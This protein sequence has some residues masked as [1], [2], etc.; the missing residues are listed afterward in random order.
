MKTFSDTCALAALLAA[1]TLLAPGA[2]VWAA[3]PPPPGAPI[4]SGAPA[5]TI[6]TGTYFSFTPSALDPDGNALS[7]T[8]ANKPS[9]ATFSSVTGMLSGTPTAGS[10]S[11]IQISVSDGTYTT[12][13]ASFSLNVA[14][15]GATPVPVLEGWWLFSGMLGGVGLLARG[16]KKV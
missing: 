1:L 16:R 9:W 7:F 6:A 13:L 15:A 3:P 2:T 5:G 14:A 8:I 12:A 11:N 4:I 10:Y